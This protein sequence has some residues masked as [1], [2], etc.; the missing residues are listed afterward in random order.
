[1]FL[2]DFFAIFGF[3]SLIGLICG[4]VIIKKEGKRLLPTEEEVQF[5][6]EKG[7]LQK[8]VKP[9]RKFLMQ[10]TAKLRHQ[11]ELDAYA[12]KKLEQILSVDNIPK[13]E[14][15]DKDFDVDLV[16]N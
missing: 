11:R 15:K 7:V 5:L 3:I 12:D 8:G 13:K 4:F 1:M 9:K 10:E 14:S 2:Y 16:E 6:T